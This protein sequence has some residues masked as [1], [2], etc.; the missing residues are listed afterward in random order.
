MTFSIVARDDDAWGV[1]VASKFVAV[2]SIVP[3]VGPG[4]G[5]VATQAM[6]RFAYRQ[7]L[8]DALGTGTSTEQALAEAL[9]ADE[10]R[11]DRQVGVVGRDGAATFT[12]ADC[13]AWAGGRSGG[14]E[15][16]A[17]AVQGNILT[18]PEVVEAMERAWLDSAG[19]PL[20]HRLLASLLA[21]DE[22]GGDSR[23]RQSAALLAHQPGAGYDGSGILA[24]LRVDEHPEAP[25]ELA[26]LHAIHTLYFG[27]P[28]DVQQLEGELAQEVAD[29]LSRAG[30]PGSTVDTVE[31]DLTSWMGEANLETRHVP[32]GIDGRV[33]AELRKAAGA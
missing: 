15:T 19:Q 11:K 17:Y 26:R 16:T 7:E 2:G 18:G 24:D 27:A 29:L 32:G 33:L 21:G 9:A 22:A 1:A 14:D 23:G 13:F 30:R 5:A 3:Q 8:L 25:T 10:G 31:H 28:E 4:V 6:A 20:D 12:G